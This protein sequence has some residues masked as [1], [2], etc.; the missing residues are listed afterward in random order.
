MAGQNTSTLRD[1][2]LLAGLRARLGRLL[3]IDAA[4]LPLIGKLP[5]ER[6]TIR[7]AQV[8]LASALLGIAAIGYYVFQVGK[9]ARNAEITAYLQMASQRVALQAERAAGGEALALAGLKEA[10]QGFAEH[11]GELRGNNPVGE[12]RAELDALQTRWQATERQVR[13]LLAQRETLAALAKARTRLV[14]RQAELLALTGEI[15]PRLGAEPAGARLGV[16]QLETLSQRLAG[17]CTGML[18][19]QAI[20]VEAGKAIAADIALFQRV[21]DGL[22]A[23]DRTLAISQSRSAE[24]RE[25]LFRIQSAFSDIAAQ[26]GLF[27]RSAAQMQAAQRAAAEIGRASEQAFQVAARLAQVHAPQG[28]PLA[29]AAAILFAL[30]ALACLV[31]LGLI[32]VAESRRRANEM[33]LETR[34]NQD[35][36]LRLLNEMGELAEG[37]LTI[38]ASVTEDITGAIA[39]AVNFAIEELRA[40]VENVNRAAE[41]VTAATE[42]AKEIAGEML[43]SADRQS[44]EVAMTTESVNHMSQSIAQVSTHAGESARVAEQSLASARRG[45]D[46]VRSAI[47]GM[48]AIRDQIQDTSKRI[49]R[50]GESSQ[51]IG[52]ILDLITGITEQTN[53][54]A[55]NA[56][57]QAAA[58]GEAGRGF[59]VVAEEV[60][61]LAERSGQATRRIGALVKTIQSDT[62]EAVHAMALS[63]Q[64]VV[65]GTSLSDAAGLALRDIETVSEEL[66]RLIQSISEATTDQARTAAQIANTMRRILAET[67]Q[68]EE[69]AQKSAQ[70]IA[71]LTALSDELK[72]S[73]AGFKL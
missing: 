28:S 50:L 49:K 19:G 59:T 36:I 23:G 22:L 61:R 57:I 21:L 64:G 30:L 33:A 6:R 44:Q 1:A 12:I 70:S 9:P 27:A 51:E 58:A 45:G 7:L 29:L 60:Q 65:E 16:Y 11:L 2:G 8:L 63:T 10:S 41:Q 47:T 5:P 66:A 54:L 15:I 69:S 46:A 31:L 4:A 37:N 38:R 20:E 42:V 56:A 34:R 62:Q 39:D 55:V 72:V 53:V 3:D 35:A 68:T 48:E 14:A 32:S 43:A 40:L 13:S 17:R 26:A 67:R 18:A 24:V 52:E 25:R 71:D 73:V